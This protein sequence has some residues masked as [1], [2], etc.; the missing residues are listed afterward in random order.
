M[1]ANGYAE[2]I[3]IKPIGSTP[4]HRTGGAGHFFFPTSSTSRDPQA[5]N[6][7]KALTR[8]GWPGTPRSDRPMVSTLIGRADTTP[9][10]C[11]RFPAFGLGQ[12]IHPEGICACFHGGPGPIQAL[13]ELDK[14]LR[15]AAIDQAAAAD[16]LA[17]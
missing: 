5:K 7:H 9:V 6:N 3:M 15:Q 4:T 2:S 10:P 1:Y 12:Y 14:V 13:T 11:V 17:A 8:T 16:R